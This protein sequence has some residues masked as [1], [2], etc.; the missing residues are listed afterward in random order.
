MK[1][2]PEQLRSLDE[3]ALAQLI[4]EISI[5]MGMNP[6]RAKKASANSPAVKKMLQNA[7]SKDINRILSVVGEQRAQ[8][9][10]DSIKK[11]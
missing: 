4:Y 10:P 2:T 6:E 7:D 9:I 5:A 8:K 3:E 1:I 11:Q